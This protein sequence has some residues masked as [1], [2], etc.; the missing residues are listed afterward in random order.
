MRTP[1]TGRKVSGKLAPGG[2]VTQALLRP[3]ES[4]C[5]GEWE[6]NQSSLGSTE[7]GPRANQQQ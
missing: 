2:G 3:G 4:C 7:H 1:S 5:G 6:A